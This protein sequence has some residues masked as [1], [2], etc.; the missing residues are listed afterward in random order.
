MGNFPRLAAK[1]L[2]QVCLSRPR[3]PGTNNYTEVLGV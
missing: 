2:E 3:R 1:L